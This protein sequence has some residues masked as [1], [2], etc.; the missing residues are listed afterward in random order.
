MY[1]AFISFSTFALGSHTAARCPI[2]NRFRARFRPQYPAPARPTPTF[3]PN[4]YLR[5]L[6]CS[7]S[8]HM[9][10]KS[11]CMPMIRQKASKMTVLGDSDPVVSR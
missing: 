10:K 4:I 2:W 1:E 9:A 11:I 8:I 6:L 3:A 7:M 5:P